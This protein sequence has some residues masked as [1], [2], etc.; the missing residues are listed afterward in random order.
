MISAI[1]TNIFLDILRPNPDFIE[2]SKALL[3]TACLKGLLGNM[4][5]IKY[6]LYRFDDDYYIFLSAFI[7]VICGRKNTYSS[8]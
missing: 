8:F 6:A 2:Q 4:K 7:C 5:E 1:D 3:D